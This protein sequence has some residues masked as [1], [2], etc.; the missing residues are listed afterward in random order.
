MVNITAFISRQ[1]RSE[2]VARAL[3]RLR[4]PERLRQRYLLGRGL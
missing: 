4:E 1:R 2:I 3:G